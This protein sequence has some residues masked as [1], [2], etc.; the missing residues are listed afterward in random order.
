MQFSMTNRTKNLQISFTFSLA[1]KTVNN[2]S[3]KIARESI[4]FWTIPTRNF[5]FSTEIRSVEKKEKYVYFEELIR[6]N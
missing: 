5:Y 4:A 3:D 2:R 6:S 1:T